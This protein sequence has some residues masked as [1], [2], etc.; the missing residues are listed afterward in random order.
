MFF[1][2]RMSKVFSSFSDD[3]DD[4]DD[5]GKQTYNMFFISP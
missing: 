4:G 1:I 3:D 5:D 2:P